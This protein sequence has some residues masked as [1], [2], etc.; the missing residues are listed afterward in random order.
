MKR[1]ALI[2]TVCFVFTG[3]MIIGCSKKDETPAKPAITNTPVGG[4]EGQDS[5]CRQ[6]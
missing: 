6:L 4:G 2:L 1:L 3:I 5:G